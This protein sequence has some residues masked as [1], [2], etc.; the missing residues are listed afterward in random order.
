MASLVLHSGDEPVRFPLS[1]LHETTVGRGPDCTVFV[2]DLSCSRLHFRL[3]AKAD[4]FV[5]EECGSKAGTR[6]NDEP[7]DSPVLLA[8]GDRIEAGECAF[9]FE[10]AAESES[11]PGEPVLQAP[12]RNTADL[13]LTQ[14]GTDLG[15]VVHLTDLGPP[16]I[17]LSGEAVLGR[18][19]A[20]QIC[21]DNP[22]VS[23][24][25][26]ILRPEGGGWAIRDLN[27]A[28]GTFVNHIEIEGKVRLH[29]GDHI[30]IGPFSYVFQGD[31]LDRGV[32]EDT[33]RLEARGLTRTVVNRADGS[34]IH[35]LKDIRLAV[36][37]GEFVAL[38]GPSGS[39]K[40]TLFDALNGR[41]V[42]TSGQVLLDGEDLYRN[43]EQFKMTIGYVPQRDIV[44]AALP[45]D[46][47]LQY[48]ARLRLPPDM[49]ER[50]IDSL[51]AGKL[52]ELGI[53]QCAGQRIASLSGGQVKK[54]NLAAEILADP[55]LL[56]ADEVTS[57]LDPG[58]EREVMK[59][60]RG[61]AEQGNRSIVV[62][63][64]SMAS[65]SYCHFVIFLV[66]GRLAY[67]GPVQDIVA[68]FAPHL[69]DGI[70]DLADLY[71]RLDPPPAGVT[72]EAWGELWARRFEASPH[73]ATYVE[74]R[75]GQAR[76]DD[77]E[78]L[79]T[80]AAPAPPAA[81]FVGQ[82]QTLVQ[83]NL[84][85]LIGERWIKWVYA[86]LPIALGLC[87]GSM[88]LY[89]PPV[90][91][92]KQ[93]QDKLTVFIAVISACLL[94]L[95]S[96]AV[97]IAKE[98]IIYRREYAVNLRPDAYLA[99]KL[100]SLGLI[101]V[102]QVFVVAW[103]GLAMISPDNV[104]MAHRGIF[105]FA[106][107]MTYFCSLCLGLLISAWSETPVIAVLLLLVVLMP[108][109][110]FGGALLPL[111]NWKTALGYPI[112]AYWGFGAA[113]NGLIDSER[114]WEPKN[115]PVAIFMLTVLT[116]LLGG[117]TYLSLRRRG[118]ER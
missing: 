36:R 41:R 18:D 116:A 19:R 85:A 112:I 84:D 55:K 26:A 6:V 5:L 38:L 33:F 60:L 4:S 118:T 25:H 15:T 111:A 7:V 64:H 104:H 49:D 20:A 11:D 101:G 16:S 45:V 102:I 29:P 69:G 97:E 94:G 107:I 117:A 106:L 37:P 17:P 115:L 87:V 65:L 96:G 56:F 34:A 113:T 75:A 91:T 22:A 42:P 46:R 3:R 95:F 114:L 54:V 27:S 100:A 58:A 39:G 52:Q 12:R 30:L 8:H 51:V 28:N 105:V 71:R 70:D 92:M 35:L 81:P 66:K 32:A 108:Q 40:S 74:G 43:F 24:R 61:L 89:D 76:R 48:S 90:D 67:C 50:E 103:L 57:G 13:G 72:G 1:S 53:T 10:D 88:E 62:V 44:H 14:M 86:A 93:Q 59:L 77:S 68:H 110:V 79:G 78:A 31:R 21:L 23:R 47:A 63:T 99:S 73:H 9:T 80:P 98:T 2:N 82:F 109:L 83:R